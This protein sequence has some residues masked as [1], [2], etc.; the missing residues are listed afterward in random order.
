MK[1]KRSAI[2]KTHPPRVRTEGT[3]LQ[4]EQLRARGACPQPSLSS[5]FSQKNKVLT[6]ELQSPNTTLK[7]CMQTAKQLNVRRKAN[8]YLT[9]LSLTELNGYAHAVLGWKNWRWPIFTHKKR[10]TISGTWQ[11]YRGGQLRKDSQL[12]LGPSGHAPRPVS[13]PAGPRFQPY[14]G[15]QR[16]TPSFH[17]HSYNCTELYPV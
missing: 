4:D 14:C 5:T 9:K 2:Q 11:R 8:G 16:A 6:A 1:G 12:S 10:S 7:L 17:F 15:L 13:R 3:K